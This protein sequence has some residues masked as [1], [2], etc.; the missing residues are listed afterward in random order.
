MLLAGWWLRA[1]GNPMLRYL[2]YIG[3][4]KTLIMSAS[5]NIFQIWDRIGRIVPFAVTR[6]HWSSDRFC[7]VVERIECETMPYGK[8]FGYST[9]NGEY[10]TYLEYDAKW[11]K[12]GQISVAGVYQWSLVENADLSSYK[13]GI[14]AGEAGPKGVS[15]IG[16]RMYFGKYR[17]S[18]VLAVFK[19]DPGY[20]DWALRSIPPFVLTEAAFDYLNEYQQGFKFSEE[21]KQAQTDKLTKKLAID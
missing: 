5:E 15:H 16:A 1:E 18:D 12:D 14:A 3:I 6:D 13:K 17:D 10:S 8:A 19:T 20:I 2:Y 21:A 11:R 9:D 4:F 7:I